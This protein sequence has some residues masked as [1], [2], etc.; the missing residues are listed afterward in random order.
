[1]KSKTIIAL[2]PTLVA[3]FTVSTP[4]P[5][6]QRIS[7]SSSSS[8]SSSI[9][10]SESES[11]A[12]GEKNDGLILDGLDQQLGQLKS[13]Y[14]TSE[15]DYLAAARKRAEERRESVNSMAKDEDWE[16][17]AQEKKEQF[18]E[19]DD[20]ESSQKEAGNSDSQILMF[21]DPAPGEGEDGEDDEPKL[22]LF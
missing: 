15:A 4:P 17:I 10:F 18:G 11:S 5:R 9:L 19:L 21:T 13:K 12:E 3:S 2:L 1:M 7:A 6:H 8:S 22:L 20:W 14:P 16:K